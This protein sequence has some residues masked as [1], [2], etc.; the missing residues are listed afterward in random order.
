MAPPRSGQSLSPRHPPQ[1]WLPVAVQPARRSKSPPRLYCPMHT[2]LRS[3][4]DC[5]PPTHRLTDRN[6]GVPSR[7]SGGWVM[8]EAGH[9]SI[10]DEASIR[11]TRDRQ[12]AIAD[13]RKGNDH[14]NGCAHKNFI[15]RTDGSRSNIH[16]RR[17][18]DK[19]AAAK[20]AR[21]RH[22]VDAAWRPLCRG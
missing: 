4:S 2:I 5:R 21:A 19:I 3:P 22:D 18:R 12:W 6:V 10:S 17:D 15:A 13:Q 1:G 14:D 9:P 20:R 8:A 16:D 7:K 11:S